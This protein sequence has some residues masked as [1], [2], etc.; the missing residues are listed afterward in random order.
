M[1]QLTAYLPAESAQTNPELVREAYRLRFGC[2]RV[3]DTAC[4]IGRFLQLLAPEVELVGAAKIW[5]ACRGRRAATDALLDAA[6]RWAECSFVLEDLRAPD[7]AR[8]LACGTV[9]ARPAG[10]SEIHQDPFVD[11]WTIEAGRAIRIESL[12]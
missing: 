2:A 11:L 1:N 12:S 5:S 6:L 4:S 9:L 3:E 10:C 8:V 7:Q